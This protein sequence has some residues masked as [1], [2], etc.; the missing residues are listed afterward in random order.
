MRPVVFWGGT[1]HARVL[2]EA[3][4]GT[5]FEV[6]AVFDRQE[7]APPF[8]GV[9][10]YSGV[11]GFENWR[12]SQE[13]PSA[14]HFCVAIGG[15]WGKDRIAVHDRLVGAGLIPLTVRHRAAFVA[16][17]AT[18]GEGCQILA[19]AIV[20]ANVRLGRCVIVN[21]AASVDH[22][23]LVGEGSH[24]G[25]GSVLAGQVR[26]GSRAF[27]GAGATILPRI[28]VGDDAVV[29]AGAVVTRHVAPGATVTGVPARAH[30]GETGSNGRS[31]GISRE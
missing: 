17:D 6:V 22:D 25:P 26:I 21:T 8:H 29:G 23:C 20:A 4:V 16:D 28:D 15:G 5:D 14:I 7:V 2:R 24:I 27:V 19:G 12:R 9:V 13:T 11:E 31:R 10:V 3:L 30:R 1:G 18:V